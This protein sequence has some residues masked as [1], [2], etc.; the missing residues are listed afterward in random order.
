MV[1]QVELMRGEY[2]YPNLVRHKVESCVDVDS[3]KLKN[4]FIVQRVPPDV[5]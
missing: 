1:L 3:S 4:P 5:L 2:H